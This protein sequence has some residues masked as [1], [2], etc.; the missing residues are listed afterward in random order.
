MKGPNETAVTPFDRAERLLQRMPTLKARVV[1]E[2]IRAHIAVDPNVT[3]GS[4]PLL[5]A[6]K[7]TGDPENP[8]RVLLEEAA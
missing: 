5:F 2:V 6:E 1:P 7:P 4:A 3:I 8:V